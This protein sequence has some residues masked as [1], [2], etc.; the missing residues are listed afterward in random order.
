MSQEMLSQSYLTFSISVHF[1]PYK[2]EPYPVPHNYKHMLA[3]SDLMDLI[4]S[5]DSDI[6]FGVKFDELLSPQT[7]KP[8]AGHFAHSGHQQQSFNIKLG[9]IV[10]L[11]GGLPIGELS[12]GVTGHSYHTLALIKVML[13]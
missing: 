8:I 10:E 6:L 2:E 4:V 5:N 11:K 3:D 12:I 9:N 7:C 1:N 13:K